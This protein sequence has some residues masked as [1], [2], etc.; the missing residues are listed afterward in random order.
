MPNDLEADGRGKSV[1]S[2]TDFSIRICWKCAVCGCVWPKKSLTEPEC[3]KRC[4]GT[5]LPIARW[6]SMAES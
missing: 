4:E 2:P 3:C 5:R 6:G 1:R